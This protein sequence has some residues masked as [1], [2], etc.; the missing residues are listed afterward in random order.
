MFSAFLPLSSEHSGD[1][2]GSGSQNSPAPPGLLLLRHRDHRGQGDGGWSHRLPQESNRHIWPLEKCRG[3]KRFSWCFLHI[4]LA[5]WACRLT[6]FSDFSQC[7]YKSCSQRL[8]WL[9]QHIVQHMGGKLKIS[10]NTPFQ[11]MDVSHDFPPVIFKVDWFVPSW[12]HHSS[13]HF[14]FNCDLYSARDYQCCLCTGGW[15]FKLP[16]VC[17]SDDLCGP[18]CF[19]SRSFS[20]DIPSVWDPHHVMNGYQ[21]SGHCFLF[22]RSWELAISAVCNV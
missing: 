2:E 20:E 16:S 22:S 17:G 19:V 1:Q 14:N 4:A 10:M 7:S 13:Q 11:T 5:L 9:L 21:I 12:L 3:K 8:G 15:W 18:A 6:K